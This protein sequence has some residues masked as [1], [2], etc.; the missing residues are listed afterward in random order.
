MAEEHS[1][2]RA[3]GGEPP[4]ED[5]IARLIGL[6]GPRPPIPADV[7]ARVHTAVRAEWR[8][9]AV[10]RRAPKWVLPAALA[11]SFAL[12]AV[13]GGRFLAPE[14]QPVATIALAHGMTQA[15]GA[16]LAAGDPEQSRGGSAENPTRGRPTP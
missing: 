11:A 7:R 9:A 2:K 4:R 16:R 12:A 14:S 13:L 6:A 3:S 1:T 15:S 10:R 5:S 8:E